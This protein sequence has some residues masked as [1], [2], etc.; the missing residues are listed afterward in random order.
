MATKRLSFKVRYDEN[1][2]PNKRYILCVILD[3]TT[4]RAPRYSSL[5]E[6]LVDV[7]YLRKEYAPK[8]QKR[9]TI[10]IE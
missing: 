5:E 2:E 3:K 1:T 8:G 9:I 10:T 4:V 7:E 6:A